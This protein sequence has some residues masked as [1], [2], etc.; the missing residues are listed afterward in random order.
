MPW[1]MSGVSP[2]SCENSAAVLRRRNS[3][4]QHM[5]RPAKR[6]CRVETPVYPSQ[7][8]EDTVSRL[9]CLARQ[10]PTAGF[11]FVSI[12]SS[13]PELEGRKAPRQ[14]KE[15]QTAPQD[16][17]SVSWQKE[18]TLKMLEKLSTHCPMALEVA[19]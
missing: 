10:E 7:F 9:D 17:F 8:L 3:N 18:S 16:F 15:S 12:P 5:P 6:S 1:K 11:D 14:S 4:T 13:T 19:F 2:G